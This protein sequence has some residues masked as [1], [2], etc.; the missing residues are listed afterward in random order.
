MAK[1]HSLLEFLQFPLKILFI[2]TLMLGVGS[3]ITNPNVA[4]LYNVSSPMVIRICEIL[5]YGGGILINLFPLLVFLKILA[6]KFE[7]NVPV[8]LGFVSYVIIN[9]TMIFFVKTTYDSFFYK[10]FLGI[11]VNFDNLKILGASGDIIPY[12]VGILSLIAAYLITMMCYKESR[13][14]SIYGIFQFIDH[15]SWACV[16]IILLSAVCGFA[17]AWIWPYV[18]QLMNYFFDLIAADRANPIN[19]FLYG[20]FER[21]SAILGLSDIPRSVFWFSERG[22]SWI[23]EFGMKF[24]GDVNIW[25][26]QK[27]NS[28]VNTTTGSFITPYYVINMFLIPSFYIA[29]YSLCSNSKDRKRYL[30]FFVIAIGLSF[31]CGNPLPAEVLMLILSPLLYLGYLVIVGL[32][33]AFLH[34]MDI[35]IGYHF[36]SSLLIAAP[37]SSLDLLQY[38]RSPAL[39]GSIQTLLFVGLFVGIVFYF[40]T[41]TYFRRYAFGLF[42]IDEPSE[43][44]AQ[45]V[46][47]FGGI[48]N[49]T[50]IDSTPDKLVV[51]VKQRELVDFAKLQELGTYLILESKNGYLIR[52]GNQSTMIALAIRPMIEQNLKNE[53]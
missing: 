50:N 48:D 29:Y 9:I 3:A 30:F 8:V 21:F 28:I 46:V 18:I 37:G 33:Y 5:K 16:M 35:A 1:W 4:F 13:H 40:L 2:A 10:E 36:S 27:N 39:A 41:R 7:A 42:D 20:I 45:V 17:F 12:N 31:I 24:Y 49:I 32:L 47:A 26:A 53:N 11:S 34:I 23:N 19:L 22:G 44:Y 6:R 38:L 52:L 51:D 14:H 25:T 15:D 43:Y